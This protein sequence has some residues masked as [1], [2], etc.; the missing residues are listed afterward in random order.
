M[1]SDGLRGGLFMLY[2]FTPLSMSYSSFLTFC[3]ALV[4]FSGVPSAATVVIVMCIAALVV[5]VVLG[6]YRIH[7]THQQEV[8]LA[9]AAKEADVTWDDSA[10]TITVNPMEVGG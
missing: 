10:L 9:E 8:K 6:I 5:V 3:S 1:W 4:L 2:C 7:L